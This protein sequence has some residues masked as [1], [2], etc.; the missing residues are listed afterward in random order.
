VFIGVVPR[1]INVTSENLTPEIE[2]KI[3][4]VIDMIMKEI[5]GTNKT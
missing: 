2:S 4:E 3:P 5:H 1:E